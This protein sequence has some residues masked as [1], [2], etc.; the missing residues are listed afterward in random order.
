[1]TRRERAR[2]RVSEQ[3][4]ISAHILKSPFASSLLLK[5]LLRLHFFS[6]GNKKQQQQQQQEEFTTRKHNFTRRKKN[7]AGGEREREK[8]SRKW[9]S[10]LFARALSRERKESAEK[11]RER[12][13]PFLT[14]HNYFFFFKSRALE[15]DAESLD[16]DGVGLV[17]RG[18]KEQQQRQNNA[19]GWCRNGE[20]GRVWN[21]WS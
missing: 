13:D 10:V 1:M 5:P 11:K 4:K 20:R 17:S 7:P 19:R 3:N 16:D 14:K 12:K 9:R 18:K 6:L 2:T 15:R 8:R 21:G